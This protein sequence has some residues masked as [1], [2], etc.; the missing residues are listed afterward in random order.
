[1]AVTTLH[2]TPAA[3]GPAAPSFGS[4]SDRPA[5]ASLWRSRS[6]R[7]GSL[8]ALLAAAAALFLWD[9][10]ASGYAN[11]YYSAAVQAGSQS[12]KAFFFGSLDAGNS[13][14]VDKPPASLWLMALSVRIG[15]VLALTP[16]AVLMFRFN[17]PDALLT[18]LLAL[19][20][21]ATIRATERASARWLAGAGALVGLA[22]LTKMLQA[23]LVLPAFALVYLIAAPVPV[24]RRLLHLLAAFA[25]MVAAFGWWVAIVEL[26]PESW[27]PY[28]GGSENNSV[29]DLV[30]G[31]NGL[32]RLFGGT[33]GGPGGAEGGASFGSVSGITRLFEGVS[34]GMV[35]WLIPAA[36]VVGAT[37]LL[38]LRRAP[39]TSTA[40]AGIIVWGGWLAATGL[41]FS[42]MAG[43]YHDYY[44][45]AL[46]PGIAGAVA[47]A[48]AVLWRAR[49]TWLARIGL[50]VATGTTGLLGFVLLRQADGVYTMLSLPVLL[51]S[52]LAAAGLLLVGTLPRQVGG[53]VLGLALVAGLTGPTAYAI[54][55]AVTP[56]SGSIVVA[57]PTRT[58]TLG[59]AASDGFG[60]GGGTMGPGPGVGST[61]RGGAGAGGPGVV[62]ASSE[63]AQLL[64]ADGARYTWAAAT[65]GSHSAAA[66]QLASQRAVMAI[67]GFS[68]GDASPT[69]AQFQAYVAAGKIHYFIVGGGP[70]TAFA[71]PDGAPAGGAAPTGPTVLGPAGRGPGGSGSGAEIAAWVAEN[72]TA[73]SVDGVTVYDLAETA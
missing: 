24:R 41:V 32:S 22:F 18:F 5:P 49:H 63:V 9:L 40:R 48:G 35:S 37:A 60:P 69:L 52:A 28:V 46:A 54:Q 47:V 57:G 13:I 43:I 14:T 44:T 15:A 16:V 61:G 25:A 19:A 51:A 27:R 38:V 30:L 42:F 59:A 33:G 73:T 55:T 34:G 2:P 10:A 68:G 72:F 39:R 23:F 64:R 56:H 11:S 71:A 50:A 4:A 26:V 53:L 17:N 67:G 70:E 12:W 20:A 7:R 6:L 31:Y 36:L 8:V 65:V 3:D 66:Y 45:V 1:M 58:Q 62:E 29:L 21:Y